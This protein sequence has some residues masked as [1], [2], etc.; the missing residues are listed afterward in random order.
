MVTE[1][2]VLSQKKVIRV[3]NKVY[4]FYHTTE[5]FLKLKLLKFRDLVD[6]KI[7][8]IMFKASKCSLPC[9]VQKLFA[10]VETGYTL[11]SKGNFTK[12]HIRTAKKHNV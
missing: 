9:N 5:L 4:K 10:K 7:A 11:R 2:I 1:P 6:Y 12:M 8:A 3:I